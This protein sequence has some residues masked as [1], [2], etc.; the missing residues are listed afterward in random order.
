M[1]LYIDLGEIG[2]KFNEIKKHKEPAV[3]KRVVG[4]RMTLRSRGLVR[5]DHTDNLC[6]IS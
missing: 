2:A 3:E 4:G 1:K 6:C 5:V